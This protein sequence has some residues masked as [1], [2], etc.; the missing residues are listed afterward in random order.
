M[1]CGL[2][3]VTFSEWKTEERRQKC[4]RVDGI[5]AEAEVG[6]VGHCCYYH[7]GGAVGFVYMIYA[8][9]SSDKRLPGGGRRPPTNLIHH[10]IIVAFISIA[11]L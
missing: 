4:E 9:V 2:S 6:N 8:D 10:Q 7:L 3:I 11:A 5:E 1:S